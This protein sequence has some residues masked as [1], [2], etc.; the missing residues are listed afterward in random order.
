[1]SRLT[2]ESVVY[3][4]LAGGLAQKSGLSSALMNRAGVRPSC[5]EKN[6]SWRERLQ[7]F[8]GR[9]TQFDI[10]NTYDARQRNRQRRFV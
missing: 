10:T 7:L 3:F 4:G 9:V 6:G 1:M 2:W 8:L 5:T